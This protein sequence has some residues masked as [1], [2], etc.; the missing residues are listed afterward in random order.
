MARLRLRDQPNS[1]FVVHK[2]LSPRLH[3]DLRL[4]LGGLLKSW[5]VPKGPSM[6]PRVK[7]FAT[8][9]RDLPIN[10]ALYEGSVKDG[11]KIIVWDMG[12]L[13]FSGGDEAFKR[14]LKQGR[15]TFV[16]RGK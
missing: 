8:D 3:Y 1:I 7:R 12:S 13:Q 9:G 5:S 2:H 16:L 11:E 14:G 10:F 15:M 6:D 4:E